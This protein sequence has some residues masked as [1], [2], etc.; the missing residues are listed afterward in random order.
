M[1]NP[2]FFISCANDDQA[3]DAL[4]IKSLFESVH[5][6]TVEQPQLHEP[7]VREGP[8]PMAISSSAQA[9]LRQLWHL[10]RVWEFH[11]SIS[12]DFD[13][14]VRCRADLLFH[15]F[16]LPRRNQIEDTS[17]FT[18]WWSSYGGIN[19][20]FAILGRSAAETYFTVFD[21]LDELL[22]QGCPLHPETMI[23]ERLSASNMRVYQTLVAEF[24]T[25]RLNGERVWPL[26]YPSDYFMYLDNAM[27]RMDLRRRAGRSSLRSARRKNG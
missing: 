27:S 25:I 6:E 12:T 11:R 14:Y 8:V 17:A 5:I 16:E 20:K 4:S 1:P 23:H 10:N 19:D 7:A 18:P 3:K 21:H 26:Y 15:R 22:S 13:I 2:T 9:V 24:S